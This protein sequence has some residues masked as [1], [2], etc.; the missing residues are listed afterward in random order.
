MGAPQALAD[1]FE[2]A[3]AKDRNERWQSIDELVAAICDAC[4]EPLPQDIKLI[5]AESV[6]APGE[7]T[8]SRTP[9]G[10]QRMRTPTGPQ[11]SRTPS[12]RSKPPTGPTRARP[13]TGP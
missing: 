5:R 7:T 8:R 11:R 13:P 3:P 9:S 12:S 1:V 6:D 10:S 2:R 4:G